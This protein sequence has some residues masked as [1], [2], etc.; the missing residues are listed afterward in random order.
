MALEFGKYDLKFENKKNIFSTLG[1]LKEV[2]LN[3]N[4]NKTYIYT[5]ISEEKKILFACGRSTSLLTN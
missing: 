2:T 4:L 1:Y 3:I 5:R